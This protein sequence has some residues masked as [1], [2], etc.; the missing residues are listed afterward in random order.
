MLSLFFTSQTK[1]LPQSPRQIFCESSWPAPVTW[2]PTAAREARKISKEEV[3]V[4]MT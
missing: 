3:R 1:S 4:V 2:L